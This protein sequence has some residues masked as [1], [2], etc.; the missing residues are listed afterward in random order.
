MLAGYNSPLCPLF[1]VMRIAKFTSC[2]FV[3]GILL[4]VIPASLSA[5]VRVVQPLASTQRPRIT[6]LFDGKPVKGARV[7]V[8]SVEYPATRRIAVL[9]TNA[10]GTAKLHKLAPGLY[11]ITASTPENLTGFLPLK[12]E[13]PAPEHHARAAGL[14]PN[15]MR[16]R[17]QFELALEPSPYPTFAQKLAAAEQQEPSHV[18]GQFQG[19]VV[20]KSG[21][22]IPD[23]T[24][25][26]LRKGSE[27]RKRVAHLHTDEHGHFTKKL[28]PGDYIAAA[29]SEGFS[30]A[31]ISF[32]IERDSG[33]NDLRIVLAVGPSTT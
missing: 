26:V 13:E 16:A 30:T 14:L 21:A 8:A 24:I 18:S 4:S 11:Q 28:Q 31:L 32:R 23:A 9:H 19:T 29:S 20:D 17:S 5:A 10:E 25:D 27:G 7:E 15:D 6:V 1:R 22:L 12:V 33:G 2:A 3:F